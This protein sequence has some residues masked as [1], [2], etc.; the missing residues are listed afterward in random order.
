M[1][2]R[3]LVG[4]S[5]SSQEVD[6]HP[7]IRTHVRQ[8]A[9]GVFRNPAAAD[10]ETLRAV[11][12]DGAGELVQRFWASDIEQ[13]FETLK[14][15]DPEQRDQLLGGQSMLRQKLA[16]MYQ[17]GGDKARPWMTRLP[18]FSHRRVQADCV[19]L[20]ANA[21]MMNG[22]W[23]DSRYLFRA[24]M[25]LYELCG[26]KASASECMWSMNW[27]LI[28]GGDL[29]E[30]E[31]TVA[32]RL[33]QRDLGHLRT[34]RNCF[35]LTLL[36]GVR[37]HPLTQRLLT[38]VKADVDR[39]TLQAASETGYYLEEYNASRL[40][41]LEAIRRDERIERRQELWEWVSFWA[42]PRCESEGSSR[43]LRVSAEPNPRA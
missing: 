36:L 14:A 8:W 2:D 1:E 13:Q 33:L 42:W 41:I 15:A 9:F 26:D 28:Y 17:H 5:N 4:V 25:E 23:D 35:W 18:K 39:W 20:T 30:S 3:R 12:G 43:R 27:Q 31:R 38:T 7:I 21:L 19:Y 40:Q 29:L 6:I 24:A 11:R 10:E 32:G 16:D 34:D 22:D 37:K